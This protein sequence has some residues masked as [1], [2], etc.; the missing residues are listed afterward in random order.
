MRVRWTRATPRASSAVAVVWMAAAAAVAA[1]VAVASPTAA[2][3]TAALP[4]DAMPVAAIPTAAAA[5]GKGPPLVAAVG[6]QAFDA[7]AQAA[8]LDQLRSHGDALDA[9]FLAL[10]GILVFLMQ[11]GFAM[12]TA[13]YVGGGGTTP[14]AVEMDAEVE[15]GPG[16]GSVECR[17]GAW[18]H[19]VPAMVWVSA[20]LLVGAGPVSRAWS[21]VAL[22]CDARCQTLRM[23]LGWWCGLPLMARRSVRTKNVQSLL[24]KNLIDC[25]SGALAFYLFGYVASCSRTVLCA[26]PPSLVWFIAVPLELFDDEER[27][28]ARGFPR[29]SAVANSQN[30]SPDVVFLAVGVVVLSLRHDATCRRYALAFGESGN[31]ILGYS[32]FALSNQDVATSRSF[33]FQWAVSAAAS[34]IVSGAIAERAT[35]YAYLLYSFGITGFL[36]PVLAHAVRFLST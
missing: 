35:V 15:K 9:S 25:C 4:T 12:L 13:G 26:R 23:H 33:F 24:F 11:T 30:L 16:W 7:D 2:V 19:R 34:T 17:E 21:G 29:G 14:S 18:W 1:T 8:M 22:T 28:L 3:P 20:R 5:A 32:E 6:R 27:T 10:C 36:Y 31:S